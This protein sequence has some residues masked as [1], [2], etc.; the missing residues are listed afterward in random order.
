MIKKTV[1]LLFALM[2]TSLAVA[3]GGSGLLRGQPGNIQA[4][5]MLE[6]ITILV[7]I[8]PLRL[9]DAQSDAIQALYTQGSETT[10][11]DQRETMAILQQMRK[12]LITGDTLVA[13]D[14]Q[15][16]RD[17]YQKMV[18]G[19]PA[20]NQTVDTLTPLQ[21]K[22]WD[23]LDITQQAALL[24]DIRQPA[25]NN[26]RAALRASGQVIQVI[27][28][29]RRL[30]EP[31]WVT[32][33]DR[34]ASCLSAGAGTVNTPARLNSNGM[35]IDF[36]DHARAMKDTDFAEKTEELSAGLA[37]LMPPNSNALVAL[38]EFQ[39]SQLARIMVVVF[40]N[41]RTMM[42]LQEI[43]ATRAKTDGQ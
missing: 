19:N 23:L 30:D 26:Q 43:K 24:G 15:V 14:Q 34:L 1:I 35:F 10:P 6:D 20:N 16:L 33:R 25:A 27:G 38:A 29:L 32:A 2:L 36:L 21:Q 18:R 5:Q 3:Q 17:A 39:P 9:T 31:A 11:A 37:A 28:Q 41:P 8:V 22:V 4:L 7:R 13:T 42:L 40:E 12:R